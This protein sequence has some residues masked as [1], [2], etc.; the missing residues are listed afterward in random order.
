MDIIY[1]TI[2]V[3]GTSILELWA[4][5]PIGLAFK[6][7]PFIIGTAAALGAIFAAFLVSFLGEGIREKFIKWRYGKNKDLKKGNFYKIWN[8]Y[9]IIG[10]G[11]LSPLIF[12]A[13]L[14]AALGIA[15]GAE[16]K[17]LFIWMSV[18]I[19]LWSVLLTGAGYLGFMTFQSSFNLNI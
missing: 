8:K 9:G 15:L 13:P 12:G 7:N 16:R 14:G 3:F 1:G 19:V 18:G 17:A 5:I 4:A 11:L 2:L 6:L 10:L